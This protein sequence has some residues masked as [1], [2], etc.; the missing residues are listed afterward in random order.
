MRQPAEV[1]VGVKVKLSELTRTAFGRLVGMPQS[2]VVR[3]EAGER[4]SSLN[5]ST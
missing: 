3:M 5:V 1:E 4:E 2:H